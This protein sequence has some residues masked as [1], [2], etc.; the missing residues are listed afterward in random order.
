VNPA[1]AGP[2]GLIRKNFLEATA[3]EKAEPTSKKI[4]R[5]S[6]MTCGIRATKPCSELA[7]SLRAIPSIKECHSVAGS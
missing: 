6:T 1:F 2:L 5:K 7:D 3:V 4:M